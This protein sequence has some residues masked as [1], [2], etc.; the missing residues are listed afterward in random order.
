MTLGA[1]TDRGVR[2]V[3]RDVSGIWRVRRLTPVEVERALGFPDG[4]TELERPA[5]RPRQAQLPGIEPEPAKLAADLER[6]RALG[7]SMAVPVVR[8]IGERI[9][10]AEEVSP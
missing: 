10:R 8:W 1:Q 3:E 4:W 9:A 5:G 2:I 7:N 6:Y